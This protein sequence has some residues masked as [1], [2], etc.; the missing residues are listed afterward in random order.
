MPGQRPRVSVSL[1]IAI[2]LLV[3]MGIAANYLIHMM[4][5]PEQLAKNVL[6]SAIPFILI[7]I[8]IILS[9]IA[10]IQFVGSV[11][12]GKIGLRPHRVVETLTISG[13]LFGVFGIYQPWVFG[14]YPIGFIVLLISTLAFILWSH[15]YP[16]RPLLH[17]E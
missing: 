11:I 5:T 13:I 9:F 15:T 6:L 16:R 12:N 3:V 7:F 8:A 2:V 10:L 1:L 17:E 14:L 4:A